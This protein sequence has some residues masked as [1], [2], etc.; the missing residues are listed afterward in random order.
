MRDNLAMEALQLDIS[1]LVPSHKTGSESWSLTAFKKKDKVLTDKRQLGGF[2]QSKSMWPFYVSSIVQ[3]C[4]PNGLNMGV[5]T[6]F[7]SSLPSQAR[8]KSRCQEPHSQ[9]RSLGQG[10]GVSG[11]SG[12]SASEHF[13]APWGGG[14]SRWQ[15]LWQLCPSKRSEA[16]HVPLSCLRQRNDGESNGEGRKG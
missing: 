3:C 7:S 16:D 15:R 12:F 9:S 4:F 5:K 6:R 2:T 14:H 10:E 13:G 11:V 1:K 8:D